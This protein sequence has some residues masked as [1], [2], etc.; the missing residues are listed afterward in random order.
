MLLRRPARETGNCD[1]PP[2][3]LMAGKPCANKPLDQRVKRG[4]RCQERLSNG[5]PANILWP[6]R[7]DQLRS[8]DGNCPSGSTKSQAPAES[9]IAPM[10]IERSST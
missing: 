8:V 4:R 9:G 7:L 3:P 2:T 1:T 5:R 10:R 6:G